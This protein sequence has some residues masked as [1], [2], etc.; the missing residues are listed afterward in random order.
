MIEIGCLESELS[1]QPI[2]TI[3]AHSANAQPSSKEKKSSNS[4]EEEKGL[5]PEKTAGRFWGLDSY[6]A[7][8]LTSVDEGRESDRGAGV[9][10]SGVP[11]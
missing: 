4:L 8:L 10:S 9:S 7:M 1:L 2:S 5:R 6:S 3:S 11:K